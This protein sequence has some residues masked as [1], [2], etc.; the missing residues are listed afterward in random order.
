MDREKKI[1]GAGVIDACAGI[2]SL[3][4]ID[5]EESAPR[6]GLRG[7]EAVDLAVETSASGE[8]ARQEKRA[9]LIDEEPAL[10]VTIPRFIR[11]VSGGWATRGRR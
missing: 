2:V 4:T 3:A 5:G 6:S 8:F 1:E 10:M 9:N 11:R 7:P